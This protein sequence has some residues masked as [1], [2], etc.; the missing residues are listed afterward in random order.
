MKRQG[1]FNYEDMREMAVCEANVISRMNGILQDPLQ[2]ASDA[3]ILTVLCLA[4]NLY[5]G[6][7]TDEETSSSPFYAPLRSLQWLDIYGRLSPHPVHQAGLL[8]LIALRGGLEKIELP[9]LAA[10]IS[11]YVVKPHARC[12][13]LPIFAKS[14]LMLQP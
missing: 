10:V 3:V 11:L 9:G 4:T 5:N 1:Q 13:M 6:P 8:Q 7:S 2:A 14:Q 12:L